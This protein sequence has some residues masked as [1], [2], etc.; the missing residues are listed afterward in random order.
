MN[1]ARRSAMLASEVTAPPT[2]PALNATETPS[3]ENVFSDMKDK[4]MNKLS[5]LPSE[6]PGWLRGVGNGAGACSL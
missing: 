1:A 6:W 4:F 5:K 2:E 3:K